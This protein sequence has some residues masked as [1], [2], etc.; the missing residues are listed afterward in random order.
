LS[1]LEKMNPSDLSKLLGAIQFNKN[2]LGNTITN[3]A[4][5]K[6][7]DLK[8]LSQC[9]NA[10]VCPDPTALAAFLCENTNASCCNAV[11]SYCRGGITRGRG[12]APMTWK[13]ESTEQG[14]KFNEQALPSS[15]RLSD[16]QF[17]GVSRTAPELSG[18]QVVAEHGALASAVAS[19]GSAHSQ[20]IL[21]RHKQT[22]QRFFKRQE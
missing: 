7:I 4:K 15:D 19:G 18:D 22:V 12:D 11:V 3:L 20:V 1:Q 5:L 10:G 8:S 9:K 14:A 6:L 17:I 13:D 2:S 16:A 21:P